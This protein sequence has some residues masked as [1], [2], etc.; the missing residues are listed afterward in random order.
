[1]KI[2]FDFIKDGKIDP[3]QAFEKNVDNFL[4]NLYYGN[5]EKYYEIENL[6]QIESI[7]INLFKDVK[8]SIMTLNWEICYS[9]VV[10]F[11]GNNNLLESLLTFYKKN[12]N[13]VNFK[14]Y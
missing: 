13:L 6:N 9:E 8:R 14:I 1:M 7:L 12:Y 4:F 2:L 5:M 3:N 11:D 10:L